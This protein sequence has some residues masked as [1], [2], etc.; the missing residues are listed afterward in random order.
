[1]PI[2]LV[3][4]SVFFTIVIFEIFLI[5]EDKFTDP[6]RYHVEI[7]GH[8][9][10][11][12]D[13][14]SATYFSSNSTQRSKI[15]VVGDSLTEGVQCA[16]EQLDFPTRLQG[17]LGN[18]FIVSNLGIKDKNPADYVDIISNLNIK[19]DDTVIIVLYDNDIH[20]STKNCR[21]ILRQSKSE[22]LYTPKFCS[23]INEIDIDK[24]TS[25]ILRQ[26]NNKLKTYK[27]IQLIKESLVN[28]PFFSEYFYRSELQ[29]R[30]NSYDAEETKWLISSLVLLNRIVQE[31]GASMKFTYYPNT[32]AISIKDSR[33]LI[34]SQF[35][36]EVYNRVGINIDD[37]Y[38]YFIEE[39]SSQSMVWSLTDKHPS[40]EAHDIMARYIAKLLIK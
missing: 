11:F 16:S 26:I 29:A 25:G 5:Y 39:A 1:M 3:T 15:F 18:K 23:S 36:V 35:I 22:D 6:P 4:F 24:S 19:K 10:G 17:Y 30:W 40:C 37:P 28:I 33:H 32:N 8:N 34:W 7:E 21:Q 38:P 31:R 2:L 9:Y 20:V 12:I 14:N 27:T 13:K